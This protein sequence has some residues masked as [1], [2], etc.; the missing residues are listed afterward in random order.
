MP[1]SAEYVASN[2]PE[3]KGGL[4]A[5]AVIGIAI[6]GSFAAVLIIGGAIVAVAIIYTFANFQLWAQTCF[7]SP[8]PHPP[9]VARNRASRLAAV[10]SRKLFTSSTAPAAS[11]WRPMMEFPWLTLAAWS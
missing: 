3:N 9:T 10:I 6:G 1:S 5:G 2:D 8:F 4:N 7:G 11:R